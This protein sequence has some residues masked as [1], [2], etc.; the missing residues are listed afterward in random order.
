MARFL[1]TSA[2]TYY[3]EELVGNAR[4]RLILIS[5]YLRFNDRIR[6]LIEDK[7]RLKIDTRIIY[8]K[9]E[10]HRGEEVWLE[11][12]DF[13]RCSFCK[14][15]HAKCYLNETQAIITSMNLYEFSQINNNEMGVLLDRGDDAEAFN[16]AYAEARRL[17]RVSEEAGNSIRQSAQTATIQIKQSKPEPAA[18][19][20]LQG[21]D[22]EG[23]AAIVVSPSA[24][25]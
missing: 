25:V 6:E 23:Y 15:L 20:K 22:S 19:D 17:I 12:L 4:E 8:G 1:N 10:L 9:S 3:L 7:D 5:P 13:V 21:K 2:T 11:S 16:G 18:R 14:N 24:A